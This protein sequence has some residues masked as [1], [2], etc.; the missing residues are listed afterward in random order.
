MSGDMIATSMAWLDDVPAGGGTGYDFPTKEMLVEGRRGSVAF[1]MDL[2]SSGQREEL[3]SHGGCPVLIGS[4]WILN[5]WLYSFEQWNTYPCLIKK[6]SAIPPFS[7][8]YDSIDQ[9]AT[10]GNRS[11]KM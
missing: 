5:K 1:W 3:G 9:T 4:K 6:D 11:P 7:G 8:Y 2:K 10:V